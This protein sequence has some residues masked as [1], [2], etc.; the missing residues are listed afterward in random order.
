MREIIRFLFSFD[1]KI[2]RLQWWQF[3][4]GVSVTV[5][6]ILWFIVFLENAVRG[7]SPIILLVGLI[8][9]TYLIAIVWSS[10][11]VGIKRLRDRNRSG[12]FMLVSLIPFIG[13]IW[14]FIE[15]GIL[16]GLE[17]SSDIADK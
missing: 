11:A 5:F 9:I 8:Y 6:P 4:L 16:K 2:P 7:E 13:I 14:L 15:L 3:Q 10:L 17:E 12:W 1:G